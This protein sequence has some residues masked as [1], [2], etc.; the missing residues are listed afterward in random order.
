MNSHDPIPSPG[1]GDRLGVAPA[2]LKS[3]VIDFYNGLN[4]YL[5]DSSLDGYVQFLNWGYLPVEGRP[6]DW[7]GSLPAAMLDRHA[8]RL[9]LELLGPLG[10]HGL[11][12]LDVGC[13]RGGTLATLAA[14][15]S[16]R[17]LTG[18][19]LN[20]TSIAHC[21]HAQADPRLRF[22]Q[23]DAEDLAFG[24][25]S[26]DLVT[27]I[28]SSNAYPDIDRFYREV[29]RVLRIGGHFAYTDLLQPAQFAHARDFLT[30][31]GFVIAADR[32]ITA[33]VLAARREAAQVQLRAFNAE[34]TGAADPTRAALMS[35][36]LAPEG[37]EF[38]D[39]IEDGRFE[40]RIL[41]LRKV[42]DCIE[43]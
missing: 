32:D 10:V 18:V 16:P 39:S 31:N 13:G 12:V 37:S 43:L 5:S 15:F 24:D 30:A 3:R 11:D 9:V 25:G 8:V 40:Y 17:S 6:D 28:E 2:Q 41:R 19:D 36:F 29:N 42:A 26:F 34:E 38:F 20:P 33:N 1:L 27:N 4:T 35:Y 21:R 7:S 23:G 14:R 22:F